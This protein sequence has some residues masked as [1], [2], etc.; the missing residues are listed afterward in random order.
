M[1]ALLK[2]PSHTKNTMAMLDIVNYYAVTIAFPLR[3][4]LQEVSSPICCFIREIS[5]EVPGIVAINL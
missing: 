4:F 2:G 5:V 3:L 1:V